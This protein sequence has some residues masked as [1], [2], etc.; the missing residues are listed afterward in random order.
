MEDERSPMIDMV[1]GVMKAAL[2]EA[3]SVS[4]LSDVSSGGAASD[5]AEANI[6]DVIDP[7]ELAWSYDF[8]ASSLTTSCIW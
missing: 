2:P 1:G 7:C 4:S 8:G 5:A 6:E 3:S